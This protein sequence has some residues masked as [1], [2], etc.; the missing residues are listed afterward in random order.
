M[1]IIYK[2]GK[3]MCETKRFHHHMS[4]SACCCEE[5]FTHPGFGQRP[6]F[7][8]IFPTKTEQIERLR[9]YKQTL[10]EELD[11]VEKRLKDLE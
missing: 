3:N 2:G 1:L 5:N 9:K 11:E 7:R 8:P 10:T 6:H 4:N